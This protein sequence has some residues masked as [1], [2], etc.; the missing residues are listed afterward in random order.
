MERYGQRLRQRIDVVKG[1]AHLKSIKG[2]ME[3]AKQTDKRESS[4]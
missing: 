4:M 2:D 3:T 1:I